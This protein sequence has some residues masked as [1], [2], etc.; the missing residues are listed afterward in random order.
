V[1][2][3]GKKIIFFFAALVPPTGCAVQAPAMARSALRFPDPAAELRIDGAP[4]GKAGDYLKRSLTLRP[5]HHVFE[6]RGADGSVA[7]READ[8]GPGDQVALDLGGA[9]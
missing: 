4:A 1:K 7:V 9:K 8:L 6:L 5:G 2:R 3:P